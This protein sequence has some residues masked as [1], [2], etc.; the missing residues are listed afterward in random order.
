M[1]LT[2]SVLQHTTDEILKS[3][4][5]ANEEP[6]ERWAAECKRKL[7]VCNQGNECLW[8]TEG[9][10]TQQLRDSGLKRLM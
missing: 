9:Q 6:F 1:D 7:C 4:S 10:I 3:D 2:I 8:E 5:C